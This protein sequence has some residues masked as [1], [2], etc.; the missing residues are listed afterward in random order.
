MLISNAGAIAV[1]SPGS[2]V[3]GTPV[4]DPEGMVFKKS[5]TI[6]VSHLSIFTVLRFFIDC[7][8]ELSVSPFFA[9]EQEQVVCESGV[10][11]LLVVKSSNYNSVRHSKTLNI[12]VL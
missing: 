11:Q 12:S 8:Y 6:K 7:L 4:S 1:A 2:I 10:N 5:Q 9:T 3:I